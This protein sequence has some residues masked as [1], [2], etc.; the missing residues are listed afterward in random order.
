MCKPR[1]GPE[2]PGQALGR[3][4]H[5]LPAQLFQPSPGSIQA[6]GDGALHAQTRLWEQ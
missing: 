6:D 4:H 5:L 1:K 3:G 2:T